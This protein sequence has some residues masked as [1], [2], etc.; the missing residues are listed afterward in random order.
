[1]NKVQNIVL[2]WL[3]GYKNYV[4]RDKSLELSP[5]GVIGTLHRR[6]VVGNLNVVVENS[7]KK[8]TSK[9]ELEVLAEFAKW[10]LE[11]ETN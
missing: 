10:G 5:I 3:K 7:F 11:N 2:K 9:Q 8:L 1:M 4:D 6:H